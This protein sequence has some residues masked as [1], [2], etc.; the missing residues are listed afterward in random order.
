M[1]DY[2]QPDFFKFGDDS[3]FLAKVV[4]EY[5]KSNL[6]LKIEN[7]LDLGS[8]CGV[9]GLELV[10]NN[11]SIKSLTSIELQVEFETHLKDNSL[12][13][14]KENTFEHS[15]LISDFRNLELEEKFDLIVANPP[16][17]SENEGR[18]SPNQNKNECRFFINGELDSWLSFVDTRLN[19]GGVF[20]FLSRKKLE[21]LRLGTSSG[22]SVFAYFGLNKN[23]L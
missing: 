20:I 21:Y 7:C 14:K 23:T 5:I 18:P 1:W 22:A 10:S 3:L 19:E 15:I 11:S 17:F 12:H 13:K 6:N 16:Y 2:S 8:G 4:Q 9:I